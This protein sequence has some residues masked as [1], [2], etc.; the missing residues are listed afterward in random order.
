MIE[1]KNVSKRYKTGTHALSD[2]SFT[3]QDG[4]FVFVMGPSG[5]G[6]ST[7]VKLL[8]GEEVPTSGKVIVSGVD[9]GRLKKSKVYLYRRKIGVVFQD[10]RLLPKKTVFENIAYA[11]EILDVPA[12]KIRKRVRDV[13]KLV[14]LSD[15][16]NALPDSLS[17]GQ[18]QRVAI[19][20]SVVK[21]PMIIIAD[22]PTGNLDE[23]LTNEMIEL[24]EKINR[25]E[26]TTIIVVTHNI[27]TV[28][29]HPKRTIRIENGHIVSD[30]IYKPKP[31]PKP[32]E[33][34]V[35]EEVV[36]PLADGKIFSGVKDDEDNDEEEHQTRHHIS[37]EPDD[38]DPLENLV[39][40]TDSV[41]P[42]ENTAM[43]VQ[44]ETVEETKD[45]IEVFVQQI[46]PEPENAN[47]EEATVQEDVV[48]LEEKTE[49]ETVEEVK[50]E[51]ETAI[52]QETIPEPVKESVLDTPA[53]VETVKQEETASTVNKEETESV[54]EQTVTDIS[55]DDFTEQLSP[56]INE[57]SEADE[58]A[59]DDFTEQFSPVTDTVIKASELSDD[60]F[61]IEDFTSTNKVVADD[62][63]QDVLQTALNEMNETIEMF[64]QKNEE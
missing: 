49:P 54:V 26:K 6:K 12:D 51:S 29:N 18:Q 42:V 2:V 59:D 11:L 38:I 36:E 8:D 16:A 48:K 4:E 56:V 40:E 27:N 9:V 50:E 33:K 19:A 55:D 53:E 57:T 39:I 52:K 14:D 28:E 46:I 20:R 41:K 64:K 35:V 63:E 60:E 3:V 37:L 13:L 21:K 43:E 44:P 32:V 15:K 7:L 24:L 58:S 22:E 5:A 62:S 10:F 61:V 34:P 45:E 47:K 1:L 30:S 31:K 25:D 23:N 17:G